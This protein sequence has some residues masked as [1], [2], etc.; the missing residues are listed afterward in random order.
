MAVANRFSFAQILAYGLVLGLVCCSG[1]SQ[2]KPSE[3]Q[4]RSYYVHSDDPAMNAAMAKGQRTYDGFLKTFLNRKPSQRFFA[5]KYPF[6]SGNHIEYLWLTNLNL[7][8]LP[9]SGTIVDKPETPGLA[10]GQLVNF[11]SSN[12]V[13]WRYVEDNC[14]VGDFTTRVLLDALSAED[15]ASATKTMLGRFCD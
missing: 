11:D 15:R 13:D 6:K 1:S 10:F 4:D 2:Q 7:S 3:W 12:V 9:A 5:V 14:I 8:T